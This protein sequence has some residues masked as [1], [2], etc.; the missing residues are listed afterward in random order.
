L[1]GVGFHEV[2][3]DFD[4]YNRY[5]IKEF[6]FK[7]LIAAVSLVIAVYIIALKGGLSAS[8]YFKK[9]NGRT[10]TFHFF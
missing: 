6:T 2:Y 3:L 7:I 1:N 4:L 8:C 10:F 5:Q 9:I